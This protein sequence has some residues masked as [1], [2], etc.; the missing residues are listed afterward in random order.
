MP[1]SAYMECKISA[2]RPTVRVAYE[3]RSVEIMNKSAIVT[4]RNSGNSF[5]NLNKAG[6]FGESY[7]HNFE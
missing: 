6:Y 4:V 3:Q 7:L 5:P 2:L 1:T